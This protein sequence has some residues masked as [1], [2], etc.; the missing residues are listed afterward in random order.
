MDSRG[1]FVHRPKDEDEA[2]KSNSLKSDFLAQMSHEIRTPVNTILSFSSLIKESLED[3]LDDELLDSFNM[4][5]NGGT[6]LIRT[7]DLILN[8]S[9]I[10]SGN[11]TLSPSRLNLVKILNDLVSEF[12]RVAKKESLDLI[13]ESKYKLLNFRR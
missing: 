11:L 4:I 1:D 5:E 2:E 13:F 7:I 6:R 12:R 10:Q 3:H 8:V 9:Q